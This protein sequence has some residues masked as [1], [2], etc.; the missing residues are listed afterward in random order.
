MI[1][2]GNKLVMGRKNCWHCHEGTVGTNVTCTGC[3][4]TGRSKSGKQKCRTC[5]GTKTVY[6]NDIRKP[7]DTCKGN[8][9]NF[10]EET[11]YDHMPDAVWQSL[12]FKVYRHNRPITGNEALLGLGCVYSSQDYGAAWDA[13]NDEALI[14]SVKASGGHQAC[15]VAKKDGTLCDHV[16]IFVS[17]GG[18]SVR[19][20]LSWDGSPAKA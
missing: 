17:R 12:T 18:Y 16:G 14:A 1:R 8:P 13:N 15:K 3:Q 9:V 4:G 19:A 20:C 10:N 7:C 5:R 2:E 6:N 11:V